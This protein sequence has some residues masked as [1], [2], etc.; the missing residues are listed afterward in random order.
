MCVRLMILLTLLLSLHACAAS[1]PIYVTKLGVYA[2][3]DEGMQELTNRVQGEP[4]WDPSDRRTLLAPSYFDFDLAKVADVLP[5][6]KVV[7]AFI[8][9][10]PD[11]QI[12]RAALL[13]SLCCH[14]TTRELRAEGTRTIRPYIPCRNPDGNSRPRGL[15]N[16]GTRIR[17]TAEAHTDYV[18]GTEPRACRHNTLERCRRKTHR[19]LCHRSADSVANAAEQAA[20]AAERPKQRG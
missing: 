8:V 5:R 3:T 4:R 2:D 7:Q 20:A 9:N 6:V 18:G 17:T 16:H 11:V 19:V 1:E 15:Q 13:V 12:S 10:I 14:V